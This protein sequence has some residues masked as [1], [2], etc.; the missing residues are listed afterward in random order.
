MPCSTVQG[1]RDQTAGSK[2][3]LPP[4]CPASLGIV[5]HGPLP[6]VLERS[7]KAPPLLTAACLSPCRLPAPPGAAGKLGECWMLVP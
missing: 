7:E 2:S 3:R 1:A 4:P 6:D 5:Q